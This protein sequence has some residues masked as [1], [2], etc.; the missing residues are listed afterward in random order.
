MNT[1]FDFATSFAS[2]C[3]V[4]AMLVALVRGFLGPAAQDRV[5]AF[6]TFYIN[7]MLSLLMM[8]IRSGTEVYFELALL[9]AVF[10]FVGTTA[11]A[12]FFVRGEVIE[13]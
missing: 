7:G 2:F 10:G 5:L 12:K 11:L 8:G 1:F 4:A 13:P 3:F 9:I 6:D